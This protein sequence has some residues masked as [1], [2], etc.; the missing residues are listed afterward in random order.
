M[1]KALMVVHT[2]TFFPRMLELAEM[3]RDSGRYAPVFLLT[4][5]TDAAA[6]IRQIQDAGLA[7][8]ALSETHSPQPVA[9]DEGPDRKGPGGGPAVRAARWVARGL[10]AFAVRGARRFLHMATLWKP[11]R[12]LRFARRVMSHERPAIVILAL[13]IPQYDTAEFIKAARTA[14]IPSVFYLSLLGLAEEWVEVYSRDPRLHGRSPLNRFVASRYPKWVY[15]HQDRDVLLLPAAEILV[16]EWLGLAPPQPWFDGSSNADAV[17]AESAVLLD[18]GVSQG[19]QTDNV[20]LTGHTVHDDMAR[21]AARRAESLD[22]IYREL[23]LPAGRPLILTSII[24]PYYGRERPNPLFD[25]YR[26]LVE[27]WFTSLA[28]VPGFNVIAVL[29][30]SMSYEEMQYIEQWGIRISRRSTHLL[31]PLCHLFVTS[32]SSTITYASAC[33]KPVINFDVGRYRHRIYTGPGIITV[34]DKDDFL[35]ELKRLTTDDSAYAD[36]AAAQAASAPRWGVLDGRAGTRLLSLFDD[37]VEK[38][39]AAAQ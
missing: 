22:E 16:K 7:V 39:Q 18:R 14:G 12:R 30:P 6:G 5:W 8:S 21:V 20:V 9:R 34:E 31:L 38:A 13:D 15:R 26:E 36:I 23:G 10:P 3:L 37:L 19:L 28:E 32:Q 1:R 35:R 33:G 25:S 2:R 24:P 4:G 11:W 27:F 17:V 29:H